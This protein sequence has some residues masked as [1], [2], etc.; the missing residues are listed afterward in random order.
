MR[1]SEQYEWLVLSL[2]YLE[3]CFEPKR[4]SQRHLIIHV[5]ILYYIK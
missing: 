2:N 1:L 4:L 5:Y 3:Y